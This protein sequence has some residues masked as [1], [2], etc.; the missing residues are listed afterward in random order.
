ME[1]FTQNPKLIKSH[2]CES[3]YRISLRRGPDVASNSSALNSVVDLSYT[4]NNQEQVSLE[5]TQ[6]NNDN[7]HFPSSNRSV[8]SESGKLGMASIQYRPNWSTVN[9]A[10]MQKG[11]AVYTQLLHSFSFLA[12]KTG[13]EGMNRSP[14]IIEERINLQRGFLRQ[15]STA[16]RQNISQQEKI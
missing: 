15:N 4:H 12:V 5:T 16:Q 10:V 11:S 6:L 14:Q 9:L 13:N 3:T 1:N 7:S 2:F 8:A